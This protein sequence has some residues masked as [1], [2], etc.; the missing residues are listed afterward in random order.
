MLWGVV[1]GMVGHAG[2]SSEGYAYQCLYLAHCL[3]V[4]L[5]VSSFY[6]IFSAQWT[7]P[8]LIYRNGLKFPQTGNQVAEPKL[9]LLPLGVAG[10]RCCNDTQVS[11]ARGVCVLHTLHMFTFS[12]FFLYRHMQVH[13]SLYEYLKGFSHI[14]LVC[15]LLLL[16]TPWPRTTRGGKG[17]ISADSTF[18]HKEKAGNWR[19]EL[20]QKQ[21]I[22]D[23]YWLA[24]VHC[25]AILSIQ[26]KTT[27]PECLHPECT[28]LSISI[29]NQE[30]AP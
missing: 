24:S 5:D 16:Y 10:R 22:N 9:T 13:T 19:Q 6:R 11:S 12:L 7:S 21:G 25:S 1:T 20:K 27:C 3:L 28:G 14:V 8:C 17:F 2:C 18:H 23:A 4:Y 30:N 29:S 26:A 15:F